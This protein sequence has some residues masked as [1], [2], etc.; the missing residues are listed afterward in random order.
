MKINK[1]IFIILAIALLICS[2]SFGLSCQELSKLSKEEQIEKIKEE[3]KLLRENE[4][5]EKLKEYKM[6]LEF[7]QNLKKLKNLETTVSAKSLDKAKTM[8][9]EIFPNYKEVQQFDGPVSMAPPKEYGKFRIDSGNIGHANSKHKGI[10]HI[11][12]YEIESKKE[13][14][15]TL[16]NNN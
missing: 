9:K 5:F 15:I 4:H 14:I 6:D 3:G 10:Q 2:I 7:S 8:I 1:L 12:I 11:H 13:I 16:L